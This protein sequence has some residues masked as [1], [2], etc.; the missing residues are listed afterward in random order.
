MRD[1][2]VL[3]DIDYTIFDTD[4]FK[5]SHL[6]NHS[7][8][9]EVDSVL[10]KL[11]DIAKLGIF[12]EGESSFQRDKLKKTGIGKYF[13]NQDIYIFSKKEGE[14]GSIFEKYKDMTVFLVDDKLN[15]LY[16]AKKMNPLLLT[17]WVKRGIYAENQ[18]PIKDFVS[19]Y[20]IETL[21]QLPDIVSARQ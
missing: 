5:K 10:E 11:S 14:L 9:E 1:K 21:N 18:E 6:R 2:V 19:D 12:S 4:L 3:F 15:V 13:Q 16:N 8:Y 17:I 20:T 7:V